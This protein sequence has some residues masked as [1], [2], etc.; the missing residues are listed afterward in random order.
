MKQSNITTYQVPSTLNN[1]RI[2]TALATLD[3]SRTRSVWQ[4]EINTGRV[5]VHDKIV[6]KNHR[7]F[8]HDCIHIT[9]PPQSIPASIPPDVKTIFVCNDYIIID[10]PTGT[11]VH[12][13]S[14][15]PQGTTLIDSVIKTFPDIQTIDPQSNRPGI[16]HRLDR[17]VSGVM[18]IARTHT[19]FDH[20]KQQFQDRSIKKEYLALVYGIPS[21]LEGEIAFSIA[22]SKTTGKMSARPQGDPGA[23][24]AKTHYSVIH[25][26]PPKYSLLDIRILT[27][28]THQIRIH[29]H[30]LG[31][32]IVGDT[33]YRQKKFT[34]PTHL[35]RIFL[36]S[37][38][39]GFNDL[40]GTY[41]EY[42]SPLPP[43]LEQFLKTL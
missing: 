21:Q 17:D 31:H 38:I 39:L 40:N 1:T 16:V 8:E 18:V 32:S 19:M 15:H 20:L 30:A 42:S 23:R 4:K 28:R 34:P 10:K 11:V 7:V 14:I 37:H 12:P 22:R 2:D 41:Q 27:G 9:P 25:Q 24:I 3:P 43:D 35:N 13:D 26:F 5:A 6:K 36:H 33:L 29:L